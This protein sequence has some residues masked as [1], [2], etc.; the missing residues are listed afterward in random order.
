MPT[1]VDLT[2]FI[3]DRTLHITDGTD[4]S[5]GIDLAAPYVHYRSQDTCTT[6][7]GC[8]DWRAQI[9]MSALDAHGRAPQIVVGAVDFL[10]LQLGRQ[11]VAELLPYFDD[12]ATAFADLFD[13]PYLADDLDEDDAFSAG[14]PISTVLLVLS[15]DIDA[16][17]PD[18][19]LR[20]WAVAHTVD[21]M[22]PTTAGLVA[23][24]ATTPTA[25]AKAAARSLVSADIVDPDWP[26]VGCTMIPGHP[27]LFGQATAYTY[28]DDARA[29]RDEVCQDLV[30]RVAAP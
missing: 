28:L 24:H 17:L 13:G 15:A 6:I 10:I 23:M 9:H 21:T 5:T 18:S 22:L 29:A 11:P 2:T 7:P 27:R 25:S 3:R 19:P 26:R 8:L 16:D 4:T 1:A 14:M 12:R 30:L 20:A